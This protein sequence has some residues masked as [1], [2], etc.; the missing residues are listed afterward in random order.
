MKFRTSFRR[1]GRLPIRRWPRPGGQ[2]SQSV[3]RCGIRSPES[4]AD[5][6]PFGGSAAELRVTAP[7]PPGQEGWG[8][9]ARAGVQA[10]L[11]VPKNRLMAGGTV[12]A[13]LLVIG[14]VVFMPGGKP[15]T[16]AARDRPRGGGSCSR[17]GRHPGGRVFGAAGD[18]P[19]P[20]P[21]G[22]HHGRTG[23]EFRDGQRSG[24]LLHAE[25][26]E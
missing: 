6:S 5:E 8:F 20:P 2:R 11:Q 24:Q 17:D 12:V 23:R 9:A 19:S 16:T 26:P 10:W 3:H 25:H 7:G 1:V 14:A 4:P 21:R 13:I 15:K 18:G 22:D